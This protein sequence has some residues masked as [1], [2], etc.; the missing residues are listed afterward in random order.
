[1][2]RKS[3]LTT[4]LLLIAYTLFIRY[5]GNAIYRTAQTTAQRNVVKAEEFIYEASNHCDTLVVGSSMSE[6]L[7]TER[8][9]P[10]CYNLSFSGLS[11]LDGLTLIHSSGHVPKVLFV[12]INSIAR[13][14]PSSL[15][16]ATVNDP[17]ERRL[18]RLLPFLRQKYQ[19]VG[20]LKALL[21]D[22]QNGSSNVVA[23]ESSFRLDTAL[24]QKMVRQLHGSLSQPLSIEATTRSFR[25]AKVLLSQLQRQGTTIVLFEMPINSQ[26]ENLEAPQ[27]IRQ[28]ADR[29]FPAPEY[30]HIAL[31]TDAFR[32]S[33][34]VHLLY[35]ES[36]RYTDYLYTQYQQLIAVPVR[37]IGLNR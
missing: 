26:L 27:T 2:I 12:E 8:L 23:P 32:T 33:D 36:V 22:W 34:G 18:K 3:I 35:D 17:T 10:H 30:Q 13:E 15:N 24:Q 29:Y 19:P 11:A 4:I 14:V 37:P 31:P 1:M 9:T 21:R 16:L 28:Y 5:Y 7:Q 20:V 25:Q 6:R